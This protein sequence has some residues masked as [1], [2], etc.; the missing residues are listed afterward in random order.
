MRG[1]WECRSDGRGRE[2]DCKGSQIG[3]TAPSQFPLSCERSERDERDE[4]MTG[5]RLNE[6]KGEEMR[7][8]IRGVG[9]RCCCP[10]CHLVVSCALV[11][12]EG[13][14]ELR[15]CGFSSSSSFP[16]KLQLV[17][18]KSLPLSFFFLVLPT[19]PEDDNRQR[20]RRTH[21]RRCRVRAPSPSKQKERRTVDPRWNIAFPFAK[22]GD[23][24]RVPRRSKG[25]RTETALLAV[26]NRARNGTKSHFQR[27]RR[28]SF[29]LRS[30]CS[31]SPSSTATPTHLEPHL[32][33]DSV[34]SLSLLFSFVRI[35]LN[36][37]DTQGVLP[38]D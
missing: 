6:E 15:R 7:R 26:G 10:C 18:K 32:R 24:E 11:V 35:L 34:S 29:L 33:S 27:A 9:V 25:G 16:A 1:G 23:E 21:S 8:G 38:H 28:L 19:G 36:P 37:L 22:D 17:K 2:G 31:P 5:G 20:E 14:K 13:G 12:V 3:L 30:Q 4:K